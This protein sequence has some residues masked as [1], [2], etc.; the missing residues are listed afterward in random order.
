MHGV[1]SRA[2]WR[3]RA[4]TGYSSNSCS[5]N[6]RG[7]RKVL[8]MDAFM[9][10]AG[11]QVSLQLIGLKA[12]AL[13]ASADSCSSSYPGTLAGKS[14]VIRDAVSE[15]PEECFPHFSSIAW[16]MVYHD[17]LDRCPGVKGRS[18]LQ[19]TPNNDRSEQQDTYTQKQL[20][21]DEDTNLCLDE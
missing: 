13:P 21:Y 16:Q 5:S 19:S 10:A 18:E 11:Q 1:S 15:V 3:R 6:G 17:S 4:A 12:V 8:A 7:V 9:E 14:M 20:D 2:G